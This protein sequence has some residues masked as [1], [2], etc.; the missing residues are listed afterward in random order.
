MEQEQAKARAL[1]QSPARS[2]AGTR[3]VTS[4]AISPSKR[5]SRQNSKSRQDSASRGPDPADFEA[6]FVIEDEELSRAGTP[7]PAANGN[8]KDRA[9][10]A[11]ATRSAVVKDEQEN[12]S[13]EVES[14]PQGVEL[15]TDV[16]VKLRKL[17][18]LEGRYQGTTIAQ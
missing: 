14:T 9:E 18:K 1:H 11:A 16:R 2:A 6:E 8:G 4:R 15:P 17:D 13:K 7:K 12:L 10:D 5:S 3:K